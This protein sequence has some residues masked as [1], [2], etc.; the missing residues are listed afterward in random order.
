[1]SEVFEKVKKT[2]EDLQQIHP[3]DIKPDSLIADDLDFD[4]L[5]NVELIME[6][7]KTFSISIPDDHAQNL[8]TIQNI[9]DYIESD[10]S[11]K[12]N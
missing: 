5:D 7:E 6:L 8:K 1:M 11:I 10:I 2:I 4:S 9:V 3:N 12:L